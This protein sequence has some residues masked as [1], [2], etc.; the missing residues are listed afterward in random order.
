MLR[1][2]VMDVHGLRLQ[3]HQ[4]LMRNLLRFVD[5]LPGTYAVGGAACLL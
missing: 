3:F 5:M 2:R 4:V 1:L